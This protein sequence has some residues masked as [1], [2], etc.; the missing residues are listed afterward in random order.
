MI[1]ALAVL[2]AVLNVG[3]M[4]VH[5][6]SVTLA[7]LGAGGEGIVICHQGSLTSINDTKSPLPTSKKRCPICSGLTTLHL[8]VGGGPP[9]LV[10]A[11]SAASAAEISDSSRALIAGR[12]LHRIFNRGP[13]IRT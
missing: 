4:A 6:T 11:S 2:G 5:I 3:V 12:L 1:G 8:G 9:D 7:Y 10:L 13:P